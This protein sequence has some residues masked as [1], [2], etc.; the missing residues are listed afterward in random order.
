VFGVYWQRLGG[1]SPLL[2]FILSLGS[3]GNEC[4]LALQIELIDH[5]RQV[6]IQV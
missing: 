6:K 3:E 2:L 5:A 4:L 1:W